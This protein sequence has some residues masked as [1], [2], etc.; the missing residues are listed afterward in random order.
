[1]AKPCE[2]LRLSSPA[3]QRS[4][5]LIGHSA[6]LGC[7]MYFSQLAVA[8]C[9][10]VTTAVT[11]QYT[12]SSGTSGAGLTDL[13]GNNTLTFPANGTGTINGPV[14]FGAG[15]DVI[16]MNSGRILGAVDQGDGA[17][18]L[19]I[20]AGT[21]TGAVQQG[22]GIDTFEISGGTVLSL[23][24]GDGRDIFRMTGGT[25]VGGFDDGD[26]ASMTAGS[27]GRVNMKLDNNIFDMSGGTIVGNLVTGLGR[28]TI[29]LSGGTIG[30]NISVSG[31]DDEISV[32]GGTLDGEIRASFGNDRFVWSNAG[33]LRSAVLMGDGD[34]SALL[35]G[36]GESALAATPSLDGGSGNDTLTLND[37][38]TSTASRYIGWESISLTNASQLDL[39]GNLFLGDSGTGTGSLAIDSSSAV[40]VTQGAVRPYTAGQLTTVTNSGL[41]DMSGASATATDSLTVYGNYVGNNGRLLLQSELGDDNSPSDKLIVSQGT[42]SGSTQLGVTNLGGLGGLT[43]Q[44][45]IEVVQASDGATSSN[46]AFALSNSVSA[47]AYQYY[48]FKGGVSAG[49]ESNWYLRSSVVAVPAAPPVIAPVVPPVIT[50][51]VVPPVVTPPVVT[52]PVVTPP[53]VTPPV[54]T[55]PVV[56]PVDPDEPA[57]EPPTAAPV[58]PAAPPVEQPTAAVAQ[59]S[60]VA[61]VGTPAL[62]TPTPGA[63]P[64][65][66]YRQEVPVYSVV[67]PGAQIMMLN[68]LGTF[69]DRQ[70]EQ[71]LLTETGAF[72]AAWGRIYNNDFRKGW[73][74]TAAPSFDGSVNGFQIG[75]DLYS[76]EVSNG[77]FQ[78]FGFF[79]GQSHLQGGV[80]G[81]AEG[82]QNNRAGRTRLDG[83]NFGAYWTLTDKS[84]WYLDAVVMGTRLDGKSRSDRGVRLDTEGHGLTLSLE[85][86]YP[87]QV[88]SHWVVEPQ[89]QVISQHIDLDEQNDGIST[90]SFDSQDYT[91]GRLGARLKGRYLINNTPVEPYVRANFWRTFDGKDTV[92]YDG[93]DHIKTDHKSSSADV[94]LGLVARLSSSVALYLGADY[95]THLDSK[96]LEGVSGTMGV[97]MSW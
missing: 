2:H 72:P 84:G 52:P 26:V 59:T 45:G 57:V 42:I 62:P 43:T 88:S 17:N 82:F 85:S 22:N 75:H 81:F 58:A 91:T 90:V 64:I 36:L 65:P 10:S 28:D 34:D 94:G 55:P 6:T 86:G 50:P 16:Q 92:T 23:A 76:S 79:V 53:V 29:I 61:A 35:S 33:T 20:G 9:T 60:P 37:T 87:I 83:D 97:R 30:G 31:G 96:E 24:Q 13:I 25:I 1:M 3:V 39:N 49:T 8:D 14:R 40:N 19:R 73:S 71:S 78:R 63:E 47:G 48:L 46:G 41:I 69:H 80:K 74:G 44:N 5:V 7:L 11:T 15:S 93:V 32:S 89:V 18:L 77:R 4:V 68:A 38:T 21:V 51:P 27:I 95:T 70:G 56:V 67:I 66:L 54:T 12:C